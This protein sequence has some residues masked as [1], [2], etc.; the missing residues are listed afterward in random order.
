[1]ENWEDGPN[2]FRGAGGPIQ[3]TR[4]KDLTPAGLAFIEALA[5]TAGVKKNDDYNGESQEGAGVFQQSVHRGLRYSSSVGYLDGHG[6]PNLRV[7]LNATVSRIVIE[8]SRATGV[9]V[10]TKG[11]PKTITATPRG[12]PQRRRVRIRRSSSCCPGSGLPAICAS[13]ASTCGPIFRSARTCTTT[14]SCR[15]PT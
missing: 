5:D 13:S 4:Q 9:D 14:C 15:S 3:V 2:D 7:I 12:D 6:L 10:I 8:G 11:G 1:M